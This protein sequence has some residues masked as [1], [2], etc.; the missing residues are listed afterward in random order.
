MKLCSLVVIRHSMLLSPA[1]AAAG[2]V[3]FN[4]SFFPYYTAYGKE[5]QGSAFQKPR[6]FSFFL[7]DT[8][9]FLQL[10]LFIFINFTE[11]PP[12]FKGVCHIPCFLP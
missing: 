3:F 1:A 9:I 4:W 11:V 8:I 12:T 2:S 5:R 6:Y 7:L 10:Y